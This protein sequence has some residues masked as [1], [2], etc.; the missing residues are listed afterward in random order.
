MLKMASLLPARTQDSGFQKHNT[1]RQAFEASFLPV[2]RSQLLLLFCCG[3][4]FTDGSSGA[5][6]ADARFVIT[7]QF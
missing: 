5:Y 2:G 6:K 4:V 1:I 3:V 7:V